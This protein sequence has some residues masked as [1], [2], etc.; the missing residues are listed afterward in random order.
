MMMLT[1][2][3]W[4]ENRVIHQNTGAGRSSTVASSPL[5]IGI[6]GTVANAMPVKTVI[7]PIISSF[8]PPGQ[9]K[10]KHGTE[11]RRAFRSF[12]L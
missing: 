5:T 3:P 12:D 8:W 1:L 7:K 4:F 10:P 2:R 11:F 6:G 9:N